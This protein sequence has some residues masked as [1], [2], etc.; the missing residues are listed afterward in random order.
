MVSR[1]PDY[2]CALDLIFQDGK[3]DT[4]AA[5][6]YWY[7]LVSM[8]HYGWMA[9]GS[10]A[11]QFDQNLDMTNIGIETYCAILSTQPIAIA[12]LTMPTTI[13]TTEA[14]LII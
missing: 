9:W 14:I 13:I 10:V 6:N 11:S 4:N 2:Q 8:H 7:N 5:C 3:V 12:L 1:C